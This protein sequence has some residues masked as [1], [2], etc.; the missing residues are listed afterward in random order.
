MRSNLVLEADFVP[1]PFMA[2]K[3]AYN[4]LFCPIINQQPVFGGATNAGFFTLA[5]T[6][7]GAF[8][9]RLVLQGTSLPFSGA[10][11]VQLQA[12]AQVA[13]SR[14]P[15][16]T[17]NLQINP[18][19]ANLETNVIT[20][21]VSTGPV[22]Y[23]ADLLAYR[24]I[25]AGSNVYSGAYTLL[26]E[27]CEDDGACFG[28]LTNVPWGDSPATVQVSPVSGG[29]QMVGTLADG[30]A[31]GQAVAASEAGQWP[32]YAS[33]YG[34]R[35]LLIGWVSLGQPSGLVYW[36]MP[37]SVNRFYT[38][39][40]SQ[41]RMA[42]LTKYTVPPLRQNAV[43]WTNAEVVF[44]GGNLSGRLTNQ[45]VLSNNSLRVISGSI[46]NLSLTINP[47]NGS[48]S[49]SFAHP[50]NGRGTPFHGMV[51]QLLPAPDSLN[52]G[53]FLGPDGSGGTIRLHPNP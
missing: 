48:F 53:W 34:G 8:S 43:A 7:N 18:V 4:G 41:W 42:E 6:A 10:F 38:N 33:L 1:N 39:G 46:N 37:S 47:N 2:L 5:L 23:L 50:A 29:I 17:L 30:T 12:L 13:R 20:G 27:G 9:G 49:G 16:L 44:D 14:Q 51:E 21:T 31:I 32:L 52:G 45:V 15:A 40:F 28:V 26:V 11:N 35:G 25:A 22:D 24:A 36:L 19:T 3:G